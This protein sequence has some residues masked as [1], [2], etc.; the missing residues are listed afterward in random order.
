MPSGPPLVPE[1]CRKQ[2]MKL[3]MCLAA[4]QVEDPDE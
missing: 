1:R 2:A 4:H 3:E